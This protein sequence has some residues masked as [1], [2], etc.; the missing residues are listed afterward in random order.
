MLKV[1]IVYF[2]QSGTTH[3]LGKAIARGANSGRAVTTELHRISGSEIHQGRYVS[4]ACLDLVDRSDAVIFGS[5]TYMGGPAA[6]FKAFADAS[7]DRWE[8]QQWAGKV[9]AGFT[10][11]SNPGGDQLATIQ[12]FSILAS[13]HGMIWVGLDMPA[14]HASSS[15]NAQGTQLGLSVH[16]ADQALSVSDVA[17]AEYFGKRVS[18]YAGRLAPG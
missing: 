14:D 4:E 16:V 1:A 9:A 15:L 8:S 10:V 5:P 11:G 7:S 17:T 2:S 12:Y 18:G 3:E 6:Q 13:Q